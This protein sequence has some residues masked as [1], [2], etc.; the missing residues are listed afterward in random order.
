[1][2]HS[3]SATTTQDASPSGNI[4]KA[5]APFG[6]PNAGHLVDTPSSWTRAPG[7]DVGIIEFLTWC[8]RWYMRSAACLRFVRNGITCKELARV[9]TWARGKP[10]L[11]E[12]KIG[13]AIKQQNY[14]FSKRSIAAGGLGGTWDK[15]CKYNNAPDSDLNA[16]SSHWD[17]PGG[18][19]LRSMLRCSVLQR[20]WYITPLTKM[21]ASLLNAFSLRC[22]RTI[23]V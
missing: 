19:A 20:A 5:G 17:N 1:M 22:S 13:D 10:V 4:P 6:L 21:R 7:C 18:K 3:A 2:N 16:G 12:I 11:S 14:K 15:L 8:P 9:A 23:G